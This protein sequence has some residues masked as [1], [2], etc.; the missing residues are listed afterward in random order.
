[1]SICMYKTV[2][3]KKGVVVGVCGLWSAAEPSQ[4]RRKLGRSIVQYICTS[5]EKFVAI[6]QTSEG[7]SINSH[8][9]ENS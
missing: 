5:M 6:D 4:S 7:L 8:E 1:M 2:D 3:G 9:K